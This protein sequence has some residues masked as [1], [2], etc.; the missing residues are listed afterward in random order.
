[1][2]DLTQVKKYYELKWF[3]GE[4]LHL[5]MPSQEI[6][7]KIMKLE[8]LED[9]EE[10]LVQFKN[11]MVHILQD[12][13]EKRVFSDEEINELSLDIVQLILEDYLSSVNA[14]LGE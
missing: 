9:V 13:K 6:L 10:Q 8:E 3:D 4:I 12:N 14:V 11:I 7:M 5:N 1:M 2:L